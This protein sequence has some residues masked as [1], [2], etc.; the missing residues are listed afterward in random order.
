MM[1]KIALGKKAKVVCV[2]VCVRASERSERI[3]IKITKKNRNKLK[4]IHSE[5]HTPKTIQ[6]ME[7]KR[8]HNNKGEKE[9]G[10]NRTE[11]RIEANGQVK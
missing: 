7:D 6:M 1:E 5:S 10:M 11:N 3:K 8:K 9:Y 2:C 4:S